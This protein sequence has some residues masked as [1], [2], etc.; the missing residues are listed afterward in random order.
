MTLIPDAH[1]LL[2]EAHGGKKVVLMVSPVDMAALKE[3]MARDVPHPRYENY[4]S[5]EKRACK[6]KD[7]RV[8]A[9]LFQTF[10]APTSES[11]TPRGTTLYPDVVT[12]TS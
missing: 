9:L 2:P 12:F 3:A 11:L 5:M 8:K 1:H 6:E 7:T 10:V 4:W